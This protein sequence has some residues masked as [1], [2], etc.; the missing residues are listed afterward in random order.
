MHKKP[1]PWYLVRRYVYGLAVAAGAVAV[2]FKW[3]EPEA[4]VVLL[5]LIL[6]LFNARPPATP[7]EGAS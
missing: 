5:P 6:A 2:Y 7:D 4:V 1:F 3:I